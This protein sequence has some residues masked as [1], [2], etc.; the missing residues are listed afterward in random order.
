MTSP[1]AASRAADDGSEL[2]LGVNIKRNEGL[3]KQP[4]RGDALPPALPASRRASEA[5]LR[6]PATGCRSGD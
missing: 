1:P 6:C 3:V 2:R 5:R 4:R